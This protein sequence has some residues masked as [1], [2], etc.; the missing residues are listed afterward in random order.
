MAYELYTSRARW[1]WVAPD[2]PDDP[3]R[4]IYDDILDWLGGA[5]GSM[6]M[7]LFSIF[8]FSLGTFLSLNITKRSTYLCFEAIDNRNLVTL[9]QIGSLLLDAVS[10][11]LL[12][13]LIAWTRGL[14]MRLRALGNILA[15]SGCLMSILGLGG[16][17]FH[18]SK[19]FNLSFGSVYWVDVVVDS[20]AF[21]CLV[22][23]ASLWICESS[24][25][26]PASIIT[27]SIGI[28]NAGENLFYAG[29]W[30]HLNPSASLLYLYLI[31]FGAVSFTLKHDLPSIVFVRRIFFIIAILVVLLAATIYSFIFRS[32]SLKIHPLN[33]LTYRANAVWSK[34][35]RE[36]TT[37]TN[38][39]VAM[40][41]Y[42][43]RHNGRLPPPKFDAWYEFAKDTVVIDEFPQI[44]RDLST[45][46]NADPVT[47][48][49]AAEYMATQPGV[50]TISIKNGEASPVTDITNSSQMQ[51]VDDLLNMISKFSKHLPD[52]TLP[53]NLGPTPRVLPSWETVHGGVSENWQSMAN[54]ISKRSLPDEQT[55]P[56]IPS[57]SE[58]RRM[59]IEACPYGSPVRR[60][61]H[62]N[63]GD[64]CES[65]ASP[66]ST[67]QVL[68]DLNKSLEVCSQPDLAYLHGLYM[69][70]PKLPPYRDLVPLFS[71][72][73]TDAFSDIIIPVP[74]T[75]ISDSTISKWSFDKKYD[76]LF[77]DTRFN[78]PD[79]SAQIIRGGH[80]FRLLHM[81]VDPNANDKITMV[82]PKPGARN[83]LH[84]ELVPTTELAITAPI[85]VKLGG[86]KNCNGLTCKVLKQT[87]GFQED[88]PAP[89]EVLEY[90]YVIEV[91]D[92]DG[93]SPRFR[94]TLRS[95]SIPFW[96]T[97]FRTWYTDRLIPWLHFV[98]VDPRYQGLHTA[99]S[100]FIGTEGRANL[101]GRETKMKGRYRDG[102][103]IAMQGRKWA[104]KAL[105]E[106]HMEAYWF[107]LLI[108]W[109]AINQ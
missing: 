43:E 22:I 85:G 104:Q 37:S 33:E 20:A 44:D 41:V 62:W 46:W 74:K 65:C 95:H 45:F 42:Q 91:D 6:V 87:Y 36:A 99:Y 66:H 89:E 69:T 96:S 2:E 86:W 1:G 100:Y 77:W 70:K 73:K 23:S 3:W 55:S 17:F 61:S 47:L 25:I 82:L 101:N 28:W 88:D 31:G 78:E 57:A 16:K 52:M 60:N 81:A 8:L 34:W 51:L 14:S 13:R 108:E 15:L 18:G 5:R 92:D 59:L 24:P 26:V 94:Q 105:D 103:Y 29:D 38:L 93:P 72:T 11:I 71:P 35:S 54:L 40:Q 9:V 106:K 109:G 64:F 83:Q 102:E 63:I 49:H 97:I 10:I 4:S 80:K 68:S 21:A 84:Y 19:N 39:K 12:W 53:I 50:V 30:L 27:F 58:Y 67:G 76:K 7:V 32:A 79:F 107:R 98:P 75:S 90:R 56:N 48:R